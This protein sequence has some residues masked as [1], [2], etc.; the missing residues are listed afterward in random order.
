M[1]EKKFLFQFSIQLATFHTMPRLVFFVLFHSALFY[2]FLTRFC[3]IEII[4]N[5]K[6]KR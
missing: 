5:K 6:I 2:L 1:I 3:L 4:D